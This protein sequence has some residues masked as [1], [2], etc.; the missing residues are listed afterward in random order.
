MQ[1]LEVSVEAT[2]P[3]DAE[4]S[5]SRFCPAKDGRLRE[6]PLE[7]ACEEHQNLGRETA[8]QSH[9]PVFACECEREQRD[10]ELQS[11][12]IIDSPSKA[13]SVAMEVRAEIERV[14]VR[15]IKQR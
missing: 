9:R 1:F 2:H 8:M 11:P 15:E 5:L 7:F 6:A 3:D 10:C 12:G 14:N 13:I 4:R